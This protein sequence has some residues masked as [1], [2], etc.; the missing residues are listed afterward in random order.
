MKTRRQKDEGQRTDKSE[1]LRAKE[2]QFSVFWLLL[3]NL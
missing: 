1:A 2:G 3:N